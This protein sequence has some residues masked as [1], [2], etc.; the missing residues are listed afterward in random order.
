MF[1]NVWL[2]GLGLVAGIVGSIVGLGGGIGT[3]WSELALSRRPAGREPAAHHRGHRSGAA[4][5]GR[6]G[7]RLAEHVA[8]DLAVG[9]QP[10][11]ELAAQGRGKPRDRSEERVAQGRGP[12]SHDP[13]L[14]GPAPSR[15]FLGVPCLAPGAQLCNFPAPH[16]PPPGRSRRFAEWLA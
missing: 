9:G 3:P 2:L 14:A 11:R 16:R 15:G 8:Q 12:A 5:D 10:G 13:I 7:G 1:E 6:I 4:E